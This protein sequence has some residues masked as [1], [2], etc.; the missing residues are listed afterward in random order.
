MVRSWCGDV[1]ASELPEARADAER[2]EGVAAEGREA[3]TRA[4]LAH[5]QPELA[6]PARGDGVQPASGS[7]LG[8][9]GVARGG[10]HLRHHRGVSGHERS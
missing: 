8:F 7:P 4:Q 6:C 9:I 10:A 2:D 3:R 5:W 1:R